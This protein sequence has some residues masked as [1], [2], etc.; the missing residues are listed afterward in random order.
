M[1]CVLAAQ[2]EDMVTSEERCIGLARM[3]AMEDGEAFYKLYQA[4]PNNLEKIEHLGSA[5]ALDDQAVYRARRAEL[6][7]LL[8]NFMGAQA[9]AKT[10][11]NMMNREKIKRGEEKIKNHPIQSLLFSCYLWT[12]NPSAAQDC[13]KH[14]HFDVDGLQYLQHKNELQA[15]NKK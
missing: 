4:S 7:F 5:I 1:P 6:R 11:T 9:D 2:A 15:F 10:W 13:L 3:K 12:N 8:T 14:K